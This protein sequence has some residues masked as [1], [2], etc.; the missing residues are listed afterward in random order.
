MSRGDVHTVLS[1]SQ[2]VEI[3]DCIAQAL[4]G[5]IKKVVGHYLMSCCNIHSYLYIHTFGTDWRFTC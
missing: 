1:S 5:D 4:T 3:S 2:V